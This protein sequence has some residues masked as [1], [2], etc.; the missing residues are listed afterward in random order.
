FLLSLFLIWIIHTITKLLDYY[1]DWQWDT[2]LRIILQI[3]MGIVFPIVLAIWLATF[4]YA[5]NGMDINET[6][7]F[8]F[9]FPLIRIM[10][11]VLNCYYFGHYFYLTRYKP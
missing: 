9:V 6:D 7:Y 1:F 11:I 5:F 2:F 3:I 10:I 4:F 8:P